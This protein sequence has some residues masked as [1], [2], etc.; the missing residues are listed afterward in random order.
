MK[1]F[2]I[3]Y[4]S[5]Y[6]LIIFDMD[7]TLYFQRAMQIKMA[8][9]LL[10]NALF[11]KDGLKE[12]N[13]ILHFR[14]IKEKT[15]QIDSNEESLY[16]ILATKYG[17]EKEQ[18]ITIIQKWIYDKPLKYIKRYQDSYMLY[19]IQLLAKYGIKSAIYS[20]YPPEDKQKALSIGNIPCFYGAQ[21]EI[22]AFKP[23]PAGIDFIL[24]QLGIQDKSKV[25]MI[26]DRMDRDGKAAINA[27]IDYLILRKYKFLRL[28]QYKKFF[29]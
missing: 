3:N 14:R 11:R 12:L 2:S 21:K 16:D 22:G 7:G 4:F 13:I 5:K 6:H 28:W 1:Q 18:I 8:S 19:L 23:N 25:I 26:G 20:D 15:T 10:F 9:L 17:M 29:T 24:K 27:G